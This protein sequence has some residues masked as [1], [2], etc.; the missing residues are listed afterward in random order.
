METLTLVRAKEI[1]A[2]VVAEF[3]ADY[4]YPEKQKAEDSLGFRTCVY[5]HDGKPSCL[6][7]QILVRH[8]VPVEQLMLWED[9]SAY[10]VVHEVTKCEVTVPSFLSAL[11]RR[12]DRGQTWG[13]ALKNANEIYT[14]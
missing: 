7:A 11:Q 10:G 14:H 3:G 1:A 4:I 6:V 2:Q 8:G 5:V 9:K 13:Q 12:Q